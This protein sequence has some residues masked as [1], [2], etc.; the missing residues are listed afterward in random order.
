MK[1]I[2][3]FGLL[4]L[5][6]TAFAFQATAQKKIKEGTVKFEMQADAEAAPEMAMLA[7]STLNFYFS[8]EKQRMDMDMMGG[9]M[10]I[11]TIIPVKNPADGAILMDMLGQKIQLI[12]L[13]EEDMSQN[14]N[15]MNVDD[16]T[17]VKY[18]E[19]DKK[20]IAG[21]PCYKATVKLDNG[22]NMKYYITEKIQPPTGIKKKEGKLALKGYPL[23]MIIDAGEGVEMVFKATEVTNKL[24][25]GVFNVPEGYQKMTMEEFTE[26]TGGMLGN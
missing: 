13:K 12:G 8:S 22:M 7:G 15:I 20:E 19:K 17:E 16:M 6:M 1:K 25:E 14:Y 10:K 2:L 4:C 26:M 23:E 18:D 3:N 21:Y 9:M 11:Q 24:P 5:A